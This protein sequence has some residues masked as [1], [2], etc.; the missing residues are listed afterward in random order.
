LGVVTGTA[1]YDTLLTI[2]GIGVAPYSA[3]GLHETL[4]PIDASKKLARTV[5]G[6]AVDISPP[7]M[8]K[9]RL[10]IQCQD[11]NA[12][13]L[14]GIWPGMQLTVGCVSEL[15]FVTGGTAGR[16]VVPGSD[17]IEGSYTFYRPQLVI[18]VTSYQVERD[19]YGAAIS[20]QLEGEEL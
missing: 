6:T 5:N 15:A 18:L 17:R 8:R 19:E 12:P 14:D 1:P 9:Y 2:S 11:M 4:T 10:A 3:R 20:W 13:A 7:Q 16:P